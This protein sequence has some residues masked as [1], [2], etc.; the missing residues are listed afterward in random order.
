[1]NGEIRVIG[2]AGRRGDEEKKL[3]K[4]F[5]ISLLVMGVLS[6]TTVALAAKD[7]E[8]QGKMLVSEKPAFT[9]TLP[10]EFRS[11]HSFSHENP[12]ENSVTRVRFLVKTKGKQVEEMFITQIADRT[13]PAAGPIAVP[14]LKPYTEKRMYLRDKMK[15]GDLTIDYLIQLMAWNP[16]AAS[17]QPIVKK[18]IIIPSRWAL[19]GQFQFVYQGEH[20]VLVRYSRDISAFGLKIS[21]EGKDWEKGSISENE[22]KVFGAFQKSFV[23][24]I[25]SIQIDQK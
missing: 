7:L 11:V 6:W 16:E 21:E 3:L 18:G 10:S 13:N 9:L 4:K 17:L 1:M 25:N 19:Q 22:K 5:F 12:G 20:A 8:I 15:K 2:G 23:E 14:P 24:M